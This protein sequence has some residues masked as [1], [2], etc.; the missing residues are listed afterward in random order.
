MVI[1]LAIFTVVAIFLLKMLDENFA[2]TETCPSINKMKV[3]F[4][5]FFYNNCYNRFYFV[6]SN[7]AYKYFYNSYNY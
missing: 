3:H 6:L 4:F 5:T 2:F 1:F 7:C